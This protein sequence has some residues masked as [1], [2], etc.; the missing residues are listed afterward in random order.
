[1]PHYEHD[2]ASIY[3][4]VVGR[5]NPVMLVAG[6]A[7]DSASWSPLV[8][9]LEKRY[10]LLLIDNRGCGR[11]RAADGEIGIDDM[12]TD[13]VGLLEHLNIPIVDVVGHSMGGMIAQRMA[14]RFPHRVR[15]LVT[16]S[17]GNV[18]E[19]KQKALLK[20]MAE[21]YVQIA[22]Q[23]WFRLL[24]QWL[25]SP[26]FFMEA[27]AAQASAEA[28]ASYQYRQ[29]PM[30]FARQVAAVLRMT[31]IEVAAIRCPVLAIAAG[32][33]QLIAPYEV[34]A[35]H[36]GIPDARMVTIEGVAHS[37]HWEAPDLVAETII[38]FLGQ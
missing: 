6:I 27:E 1:M 20:D 36:T 34:A 33:D 23:L 28:S 30:N 2:R 4:E 19:D 7:S 17:A 38:E 12:V 25:F 37:A 24:Y 29:S 15:K 13:C 35:A 21:L 26:A 5:G 18:V 10:K 3:Y 9:L 11:T 22:P 31:P 16:M 14:T 8:P 32:M